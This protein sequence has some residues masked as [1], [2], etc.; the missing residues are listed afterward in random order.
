MSKSHAFAG[1]SALNMLHGEPAL[2]QAELAHRVVYGVEEDVVGGEGR[3][4]IFMRPRCLPGTV[5]DRT[6]HT[7]D[8][9][10]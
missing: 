2:T 1:V 7:Y 4:E 10:G 6:W 5:A 3:Q 9:Q 8:S